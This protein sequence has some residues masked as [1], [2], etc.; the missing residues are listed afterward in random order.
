MFA[1]SRNASFVGGT[2]LGVGCPS[3][4]IAVAGLTGGI[5]PIVY[6]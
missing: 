2:L 4:A 1:D 3:I 6:K 5:A